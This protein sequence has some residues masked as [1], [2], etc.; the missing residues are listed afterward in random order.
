M[1]CSNNQRYPFSER[2][3]DVILKAGPVK[4]FRRLDT[5][6]MFSIVCRT[7]ERMNIKSNG[8]NVKMSTNCSVSARMGKQKPEKLNYPMINPLIN[9]AALLPKLVSGEVRMNPKES[10]YE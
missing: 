4:G 7:R 6:W 9:G 1:S 10:I 2:R 8:Q 3:I 5:V